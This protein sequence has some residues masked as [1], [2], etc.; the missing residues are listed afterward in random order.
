MVFEHLNLRIKTIPVCNVYLNHVF[1]NGD[2]PGCQS[3]SIHI[4]QSFTA[5]LFRDDQSSALNGS[6][7]LA[8]GGSQKSLSWLATFVMTSGS[9]P[10]LFA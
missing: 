5:P 1:L 8:P 4:D 7:A 2:W 6:Y 10:S 3:F 9:M